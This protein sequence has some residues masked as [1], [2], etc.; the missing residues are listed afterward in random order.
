MFP[1]DEQRWGK[2]TGMII[3]SIDLPVL[4]RLVAS[5][6]EL[7]AKIREADDFYTSHIQ[8]QAEAA[9]QH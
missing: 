7:E 4:Q 3:E 8:K 1:G 5:D 9:E 6:A 2:L